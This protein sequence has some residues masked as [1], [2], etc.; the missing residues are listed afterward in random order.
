MGLGPPQKTAAELPWAQFERAAGT[1]SRSK[2]RNPD[3]YEREPDTRNCSQGWD[4]DRESVY[5]QVNRDYCQRH[6][7]VSQSTTM[8]T[9]L[10]QR[11]SPR[12]AKWQKPITAS[13]PLMGGRRSGRR[14]VAAKAMTAAA[15]RTMATATRIITPC[16]SHPLVVLE[17]RKTRACRIHT[18]KAAWVHS[19]MLACASVSRSHQSSPSGD[20]RRAEPIAGDDDAAPYTQDLVVREVRLTGLDAEAQATSVNGPDML[21]SRSLWWHRRISSLQRLQRR[22]QWRRVSSTVWFAGR[23][24]WTGSRTSFRS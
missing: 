3:T 14:C 10:L 2:V 22:S 21:L 12:Q 4:A 18:P 5:C 13:S 23:T 16:Y 24:G 7:G 20:R 11:G 9:K 15:T 8:S 17:Q 19:R 6:E 1:S